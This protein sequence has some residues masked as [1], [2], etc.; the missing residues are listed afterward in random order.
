MQIKFSKNSEAVSPFVE[1]LD[2]V[3]E[4]INFLGVRFDR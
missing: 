3:T 2:A 4:W 1:L